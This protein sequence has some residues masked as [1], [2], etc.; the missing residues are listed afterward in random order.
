MLI[1]VKTYGLITKSLKE[2]GF[3][4]E[5]DI[6]RAN[7]LASETKMHESKRKKSEL[8][9]PAAMT[10]TSIVIFLLSLA[11]LLTG[12]VRAQS[13]LPPSQLDDVR[14]KVEELTEA[15]LELAQE[16]ELLVEDWETLLDDYQEYFSEYDNVYAKKYEALLGKYVLRIENGSYFADM[17][18]LAKDIA[19]LQTE[20][21][22]D[23]PSI[24]READ[25]RK[26]YR[27]V[28]SLQRQLDVLQ[29]LYDEQIEQRLQ[30]RLELAELVEKYLEQ[31]W[32]AIVKKQEVG[33][34]VEIERDKLLEKLQEAQRLADRPQSPFGVEAESVGATAGLL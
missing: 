4:R 14:Q 2:L 9:T 32:T 12:G 16:Y 30:N 24:K 6:A 34:R 33:R 1:L 31:E 29:G 19:K 13:T 17:E 26:L 27:T 21:D 22:A 18:K 25:N 7:F 11:F 10:K 3:R 28:A 8:G 20:L 5:L 15:E 23:Q